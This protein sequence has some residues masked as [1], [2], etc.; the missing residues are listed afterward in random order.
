MKNSKSCPTDLLRFRG[1][2]I[3]RESDIQS[4]HSTLLAVRAESWR[5]GELGSR[6]ENW[7]TVTH[8][9]RHMSTHTSAVIS[10]WK[11]LRALR[12]SY[13]SKTPSP[14]RSLRLKCDES[15]VHVFTP[16]LLIIFCTLPGWKNL[17][18]LSLWSSHF[19]SIF[20]RKTRVIDE[21]EFPNVTQ[22]ACTLHCT[23]L[24]AA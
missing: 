1:M 12:S 19:R 9:K 4:K 10:M 16:L 17:L 2:I 23:Q 7:H 11:A 22:H 15:P 3:E 18:T 14:L 13:L 6:W 5:V 20:E 21:L 8:E 24:L